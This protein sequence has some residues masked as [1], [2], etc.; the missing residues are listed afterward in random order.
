MNFFTFSRKLFVLWVPVVF[1]TQGVC[2]E[3]AYSYE[4]D[5]CNSARTECFQ[6]P[7]SCCYPGPIIE[8]KVGYFFF[9]DSKMRKIYDQGGVDV[10]LTGT[11]PIWKNLQFY[12]SVEYL[13]KSGRS[14]NDH[15]R[16]S[17]WQVPVNIGLRS[18]YTF[19]EQIQSY[20]TLGPR[21]FYIHQHNDSSF[22]PKN[23]ARSGVGMFVNTGLN[24]VFCNGFLL[25][26]FGEYSYARIDFHNSKNNVHGRRIQVGGFTFGM[27][28]G[29]AF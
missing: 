24:Y 22:V 9:T 26:L 8:A 7:D 19:C 13:R 15:Q 28:L 6:E 20:I 12:G 21:Y 1:V 23:K 27:G 14:L 11:Y 16:T 3:R 29:Y 25:D 2:D 10:Q 5:N 18:V 4:S 17:I